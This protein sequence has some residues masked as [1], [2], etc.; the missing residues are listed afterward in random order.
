MAVAAVHGSEAP[1]FPPV[2]RGKAG[3]SRSMAAGPVRPCRRRP[4][5]GVL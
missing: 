5:C 1:G 2:R 3:S 4:K